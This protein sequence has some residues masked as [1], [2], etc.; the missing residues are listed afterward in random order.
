MR[1]RILCPVAVFE[2]VADAKEERP[3]RQKKQPT[4]RM[5]RRLLEKIAAEDD[6]PADETA[7][8]KTRLPKR[9]PVRLLGSL[10]EGEIDGVVVPKVRI[11]RDVEEPAVLL[12]KG[13]GRA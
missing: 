7:C 10:C 12:A 13:I 4:A 9:R 1:R 11:E 6:V 2:A 8:F 3:V 5:R